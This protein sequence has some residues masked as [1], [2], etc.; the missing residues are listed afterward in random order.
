M[1]GLA[2]LLLVL[3]TFSTKWYSFELESDGEV[4]IE[5]EKD[6]DCDV[7]VQY[8]RVLLNIYYIQKINC[9][10]LFFSKRR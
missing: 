8:D 3:S 2:I 9:E 1:K 5:D 10:F 7:V 6:D 4:D